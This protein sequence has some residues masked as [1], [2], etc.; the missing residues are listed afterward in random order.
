MTESLLTE[1]AGAQHGVLTVG[2][3]RE[4]G[5]SRDAIRHRV[6]RSDWVAPFRGVLIVGPVTDELRTQTQAA[7]FAVGPE[8]AVA[9]HATAVHLHGLDGLPKHKPSDRIWLTPPLDVGRAQ[10][11]GI[12]QKWSAV[13]ADEIVEV[14]GLLV[15]SIARTAV[16][17]A[18]MSDRETAVCVIESA[19][20][21]GVSLAEMKSLVVSRRGRRR[22]EEWWDLADARSANPLETRA[23]LPLVDA[24]IPPDELQFPV[25]VGELILYV[26]MAYKE[27]K[28]AIETDGRDPHLARAQFV[29]DRRRWTLLR[30]AGWIVVHLTWEDV[31]RPFYVVQTVQPALNLA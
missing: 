7:Q 21:R 27:R 18:L 13:P 19:M 12:T 20:R 2:Q 25:D 24:G 3:A 23:R 31:R 4:C 5:L 10:R 28:V 26:D 29:W 8:L 14:D 1:L 15:T 22:L 9:S 17:I 11:T 6:E 16:D 30:E